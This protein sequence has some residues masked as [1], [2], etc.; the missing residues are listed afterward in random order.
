M[1]GFRRIPTFIVSSASKLQGSGHQPVISVKATY[2]ST[3]KVILTLG[4]WY[5]CF[6]FDGWE[7]TGHLRAGLSNKS[8]NLGQ[9]EADYL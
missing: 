4:L 2:F 6:G 5:F 7:P 3:I 8:L 1:L 9:S